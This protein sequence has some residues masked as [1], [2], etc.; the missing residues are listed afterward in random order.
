MKTPI[1]GGHINELS[2]E[3]SVGQSV[4][5]VRRTQVQSTVWTD[6]TSDTSTDITNRRIGQTSKHLIKPWS[7]LH[8]LKTMQYKKRYTLCKYCVCI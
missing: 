3:Q 7:C 6:T 1:L 4:D 2:G 8:E 5:G